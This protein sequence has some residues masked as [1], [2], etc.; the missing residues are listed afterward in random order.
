[1]LAI[2]VIV[3]GEGYDETKEGPDQ[4]GQYSAN[5]GGVFQAPPGVRLERTG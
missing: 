3:Y 4:G 1:M 2:E 5:R